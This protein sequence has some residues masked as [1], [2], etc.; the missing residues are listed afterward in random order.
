L[1]QL[2]DQMRLTPFMR[3]WAAYLREVRPEGGAWNS[4]L[5]NLQLLA[6]LSATR[7][8]NAIKGNSTQQCRNATFSFLRALWAYARFYA[9]FR[10]LPRTRANIGENGQKW[11]LFN[12][13][14]GFG[15]ANKT[16][17][18][19]LKWLKNLF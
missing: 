1:Q 10:L 5:P 13:I 14:K 11:V 9:R 17:L 4:G 8:C 19:A 3:D 12:K 18:N 7:R 15:A 6:T 16:E 2:D